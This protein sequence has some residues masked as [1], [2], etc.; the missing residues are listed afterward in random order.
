MSIEEGTIVELIVE[1]GTENIKVNSLIAIIET[2]GSEEIN[3]GKVVGKE[4]NE[5]VKVDQ[6]EEVLILEEKKNSV[7]PNVDKKEDDILLW[8]LIAII[9]GY[10]LGLFFVLIKR[11]LD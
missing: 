3:E 8:G 6:N 10:I 7:D 4:R 5:A 1:E 9:I 2:E 11:N